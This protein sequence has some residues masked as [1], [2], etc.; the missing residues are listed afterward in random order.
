VGLR[1]I[2]FRRGARFG[3]PCTSLTGIAVVLN[4]EIDPCHSSTQ[5]P[6]FTPK[7]A[8]KPLKIRTF[9]TVFLCLTLNLMAQSFMDRCGKL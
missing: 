4:G 1:K 9:I 7:P 6:I 5:Q 8:P 3:G 2:F